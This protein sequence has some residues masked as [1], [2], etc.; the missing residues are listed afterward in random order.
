VNAYAIA[1]G[2]GVVFE[3]RT[4]NAS[5]AAETAAVAPL[6]RSLVSTRSDPYPIS[7]RAP[8]L[9]VTHSR[10]QTQADFQTPVYAP[11]RPLSYS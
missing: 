3:G 8:I 1:I 10:S 6:L 2:I 5:V 11:H 7:H 9:T 4:V